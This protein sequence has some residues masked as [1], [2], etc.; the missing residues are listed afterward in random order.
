SDMRGKMNAGSIMRIGTS[1][2]RIVFFVLGALVAGV[3][4]AVLDVWAIVASCALGWAMLAITISD[5]RR[6]II[7][8]VLSLPMIPVG[9]LATWLLSEPGHLHMLLHL[10]AAV[11]ACAALWLVGQGYLRLRGREGLGLGDVKLA[12]VA[13]AWTG[14]TGVIH[15][16]LLASLTALAFGLLYGLATERRIRFDLALPFGSFFAPAIWLVWVL[17]MQFAGIG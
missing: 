1:Q 3:S 16:L 4:L 14:L 11:G 15:V 9:L 2:Q 13:G 7:P 10:A 6:F 17:Q 5:A 8:D 12:A